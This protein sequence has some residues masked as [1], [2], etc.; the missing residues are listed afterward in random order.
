MLAD[1]SRNNVIVVEGARQVGKSYMVNNVLKSQSLPYFSFDLEKNK[2][3]RRQIDETEDF[4]D[5][6]APL[7]KVT[8]DGGI[9]IMNIPVYLAGKENIK[10]YYLRR[11]V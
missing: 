7:E 2:K 11:S 6:A 9:T 5:S 10:N 8:L 3:L 1:K 4:N